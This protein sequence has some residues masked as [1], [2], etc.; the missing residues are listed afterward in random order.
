MTALTS[1][2]VPNLD[3][4][5]QYYFMVQAYDNAGTSDYGPEAECYAARL[6]LFGSLPLTLTSSW[7]WQATRARIVLKGG[8]SGGGGGGASGGSGND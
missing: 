5:T 4:G 8:D 1:Y 3:N 2:T 7:P 6:A